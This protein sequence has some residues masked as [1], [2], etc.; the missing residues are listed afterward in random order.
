[1]SWFDPAGVDTGTLTTGTL[2]VA[3][4]KP[5]NELSTEDVLRKA[6]S[7]ERFSEHPIART[8]SVDAQPI[9][10]SNN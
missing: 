9:D 2:G 10:S 6:A 1:M 3:A 4:V 8:V 7:L 5:V